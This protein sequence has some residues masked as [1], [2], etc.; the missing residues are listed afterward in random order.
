VLSPTK[1][2]YTLKI[3][4]TP[5]PTHLAGETTPARTLLCL[6]NTNMGETLKIQNTLSHAHLATEITPTWAKMIAYCH[7]AW[8]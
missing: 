8:K 6:P 1:G 3:Q 7:G 2:N 4:N 5:S